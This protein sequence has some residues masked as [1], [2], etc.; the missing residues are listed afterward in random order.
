MNDMVWKFHVA[1]DF[2]KR[3]HKKKV[4]TLLSFR[5]HRLG[6][7]EVLR[8]V[9]N[10]FGQCEEFPSSSNCVAGVRHCCLPFIL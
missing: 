6:I 4:K 7:A 1:K 5:L 2:C 8:T 9:D 3:Y 10:R